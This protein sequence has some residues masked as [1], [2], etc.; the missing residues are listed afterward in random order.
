MP[1]KAKTFQTEK[2]VRSWLRSRTTNQLWV[3]P[4]RGSTFGA[5]DVF[6]LD[7][8]GVWME[9]KKG[10]CK[11]R[12]FLKWTMR[13]LQAGTIENIR[14]AGIPVGLVVGFND[15]VFTTSDPDLIERGWAEIREEDL[16]KAQDRDSFKWIVTAIK[17]ACEERWPPRREAGSSSNRDPETQNSPG[18]EVR[19]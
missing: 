7:Q 16:I 17:E 8:G 11:D 18:V 5:P 12:R 6:V 4:T 2:D 14:A 15:R 1:R 3:E 10:E 9:L 13:R 19:P